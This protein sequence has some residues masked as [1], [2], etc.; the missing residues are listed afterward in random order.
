[1]IVNGKKIMVLSLCDRLDK[2]NKNQQNLKFHK[3]MNEKGLQRFRELPISDEVL[4]QKNSRMRSKN[5][6]S[7]LSG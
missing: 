6:R 3:V 1:M 7:S 5:E 4:S 2:G